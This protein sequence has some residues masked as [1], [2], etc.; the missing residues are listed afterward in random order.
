MVY[1]RV[2]SSEFTQAVLENPT[3]RFIAENT[4]VVSDPM[5]TARYP[6]RWG[7][8]M[9][10]TLKDGSVH[11]CQIDDISGSPAA[12]LTPEQEKNKFCGLVSP[13]LGYERTAELTEKIL[14]IDK[15]EV[16]PDLA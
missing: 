11:V 6:K 16:L 3:V 5:F 7:S 14:N 1:G 13:V 12:P 10:V 9:T 2:T 15:L 4:N 8:R